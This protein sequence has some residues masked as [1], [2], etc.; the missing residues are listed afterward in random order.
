MVPHPA[1][2]PTEF[3][4]GFVHPS[5]VSLPLPKFLNNGP[6]QS[7]APTVDQTNAVVDETVVNT[8][9]YEKYSKK[10]S[11]SNGAIQAIID[12]KVSEAKA[13]QNGYA[14]K[15]ENGKKTEESSNGNQKGDVEMPDVDSFTDAISPDTAVEK[16]M[17]ETAEED[18]D[19]L[20]T[21]TWAP[22]HFID[23]DEIE[24]AKTNTEQAL[25]SRLILE[26]QNNQ[27]VRLAKSDASAF[28]VTPEERRLAIKI[29]NMLA[30]LVG[31]TTPAELQVQPSP[32]YPVLQAAYPGVLQVSEVKQPQ[33]SGGMRPS[34]YTT[35]K[36]RKQ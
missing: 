10:V 15:Q 31:E 32:K 8:V 11:E 3:M 9:W 2:P 5:S 28:T 25:L 35:K 33:S 13:S 23:E 4:T 29:Q 17:S 12:D 24:A 6:Y 34:R 1:I 27:R 20:S 7:F 22:N 16:I 21:L 14:S 30:R 18:L 36:Y 26:L 19:F